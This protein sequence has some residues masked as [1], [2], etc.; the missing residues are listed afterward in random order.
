MAQDD[1]GLEAGPE[2]FVRKTAFNEVENDMEVVDFTVIDASQRRIDDWTNSFWPFHLNENQSLEAEGR[3]RMEGIANQWVGAGEAEAT[4]TLSAVPPKNVSGG[5]DEWLGEPVNWS[6]TWSSEV[7]ADGWFAVSI[8]TPHIA[9]G[10]PSNTFFEL[11]PSLSR[12]GPV[13]ANAVSSEDRTV[14]L[15]P[16]RFLLDTIQPQVNSLTALDAGREAVA[17][18]HISMYGKDVA[19]RLQ[20]SDP[21]GLSSQLEV[22]TW[23]ERLHDTNENGVMEEEEYRMQTV[24]LNR[25][26]RELEVDL[27]LLSSQSVVPDNKNAGRI[28]VVLVGEDLAGNPLW[29][30]AISEHPTIWPPSV[31]SVVRIRSLTG[32][33]SIWTEST[34]VCWRATN[35][36]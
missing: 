7:S 25:G 21:E 34:T 17:D 1:E 32:R 18:E 30:V 28:S 3:V 4:V 12:R 35:T 31:F 33:A 20:L 22:W 13:D 29:E 8:S 2:V 23:L 5:P 15:T 14:V 27:P 24:S 36:P 6:R 19:L 26:V 16:T 11:R 9:D 10:L